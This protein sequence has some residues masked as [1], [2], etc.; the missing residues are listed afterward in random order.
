MRERR[1]R[2]TGRELC[3]RVPIGRQDE[4]EGREVLT[5]GQ[6]GLG[7]SVALEEVARTLQRKRLERILRLRSGNSQ[8]SCSFCGLC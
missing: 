5:E 7:E 4:L 6:E 2:L 8:W 1:A 3:D